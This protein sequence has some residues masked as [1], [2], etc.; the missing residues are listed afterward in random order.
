MQ[1]VTEPPDPNEH[2]LERIFSRLNMQQAWKRVKANQ[3]APGVDDMAIDQFSAF[4][5]NK[6]PDIRQALLA[7]T[8]QPK[9]VKRVE[10]PKPT[11]GTRPL[12][13][14]TVLDRLIQQAI[15]QVLVPIFDPD[16]SDH[17]DGF[18]PG[19][20]AHDAV[21][22]VQQY[23]KEGYRFAVDMDLEKFFDTVNH[24]VLMHRV[25]RKVRDKRLLKLIGKYLRAGVVV[26]GRSQ[27]THQGVPQGG[28]LSPLLANI[29]LDDLDKELER[30][31]HRFVRYAD[32]FVILVKS[33]RA[34][35]R[36]MTSVKRFIERKLK[37]KVNEHKSQVAKTDQTNFLGFTFKGAKIRWSD[38][39]FAEFK[40]RVKKTDRQK[41]VCHH[42]VPIK[43]AFP[44]PPWLDELLRHIGILPTIARN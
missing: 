44:V 12:G 19:R 43:G 6:W 2:L 27:Q 28:P 26:N 29:V 13:I 15:A 1:R 39:A 14:P 37:L 35:K 10:I 16:F 18:R 40:R 9:P 8:Y 17:S 31:G 24:D 3:G 36:V 34:G 20:S 30:R 22:K 5:R 7:G 23:I 41:L 32:D 25:A 42:G 11:G 33:Q 21:R 4:A 38:K